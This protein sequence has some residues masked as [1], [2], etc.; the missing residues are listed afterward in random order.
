MKIPSMK[1]IVAGIVA[2]FADLIQLVLFPVTA[3]GIFSPVSDFIDV[4]TAGIM[5]SL[6]GW[7][8]SFMPSIMGEMV[9]GLN[10]CPFWTMA[11]FIAGWTDS[12]KQV[13]APNGP[14]SMIPPS[15]PF[16]IPGAQSAPQKEIVVNA[17]PAQH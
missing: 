14:Q 1:F 12:A 11:V 16:P 17:S 2:F 3:E 5:V 10:L 13:G 8:W 15:M 6:L 4:V 9:P 7:H